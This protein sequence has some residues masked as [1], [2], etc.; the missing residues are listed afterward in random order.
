MKRKRFTID[1]ATKNSNY[2]NCITIHAPF[3][4]AAARYSSNDFN[5]NILSSKPKSSFDNLE[6]TSFSSA[7]VSGIA[8]LVISENPEITFNQTILREKLLNMAQLNILDLNNYDNNDDGKQADDNAIANTNNYFINNGKMVTYSKDSYYASSSCGPMAG[9]R[10]CNNNQCCSS[11]GFCGVNSYYCNINSGCL[12]EFGSSKENPY[13]PNKSG[14]VW[15]HNKLSSSYYGKPLCITYVAVDQ[16]VLLKE[17]Q[18][19]ERQN[20]ILSQEKSDKFVSFYDPT[21]CLTI[22]DNQA[23]SVKCDNESTTFTNIFET[24]NYNYIQSVDNSDKCLDVMVEENRDVLSLNSKL[25]MKTCNYEI[26][27]TNSQQWI[28][29]SL[30][31]G[32][33]INISEEDLIKDSNPKKNRDSLKTHDLFKNNF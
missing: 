3:Y 4:V 30:L 28:F 14:K 11:N 32:T 17:C 5:E 29:E 26:S 10:I 31:P 18:Y 21:V 8:A 12:S 27:D 15:I 23:L 1:T 13:V 24:K 25:V 33:K 6:G 20:W 7:I 16:P 19:D 22:K 2:G 9:K